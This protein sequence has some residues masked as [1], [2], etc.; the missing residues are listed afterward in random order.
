MANGI[1][2][3]IVTPNAM[4]LSEEVDELTAIGAFGE[5]GV[6]PGH[7]PMLT[8]LGIGVLTY[9]RGS[10]LHRLALG[11]GYAEVDFGR[12]MVLAESAELS[13]QIDV[14]RA[15]EAK[16][17]A[18]EILRNHLPDDKEYIEAESALERSVA[19]LEA[20]KK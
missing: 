6:L 16:S 7:R 2:L 15:K 11:G 8:T 14:E 5:F 3:E 20:A 4:V 19:R 1:Q 12:V 13:A 17:R 18:E 10:S 9:K